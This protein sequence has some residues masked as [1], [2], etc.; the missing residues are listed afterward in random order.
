MSDRAEAV[1]R[2]DVYELD[3]LLGAYALDAVDADERHRVEDYLAINP[4]AAVEVQDHR[5]VA[6]MLAFTGMDAPDHLWAKIQR[7]LDDAPP[8]PGPELA[9]VLSGA[10]TA[11]VT[12]AEVPPPDVSGSDTAQSG[13]VVSFEDASRRRRHRLASIG[14]WVAS[15]AAAAVIAVVA[16][17][18]VDRAEAPGDPLAA[19]IDEAR[20]DRDSLVTELVSE[21]SDSTAE[22]IVDQDGHGYLDATDLPTLPAGQ[23]Y[24]L[25]GV[26][27]DDVISLGIL[28]P[29]PE[30]ETF[31]IEGDVAALAV[32]I[33][34]S[35][36]VI[37]DGNPEGAFV[38][39]FA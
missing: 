30:L 16:I 2:G 13:T 19:A 7:E 24:Q 31:T 37:A 4:R 23:T 25:W 6:T 14:P 36:G 29:N 39:A 34:Q 21:A 10:E 9:R 5:E 1:D 12:V 38:G 20:A 22:A 33:E 8:R 35:P 32:T 18:I 17:G 28:G 15:V 26:I 11:G 27:G 3:E